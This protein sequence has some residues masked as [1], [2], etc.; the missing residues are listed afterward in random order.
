[1]FKNWLLIGIPLFLIYSLSSFAGPGCLDSVGNET[2]TTF[3]LT[4][5]F[6][7]YV[8]GFLV[9]TIE[10]PRVTDQ[11]RIV[12]C[13][14]LDPTLTSKKEEITRVLKREFMPTVLTE[15]E[16]KNLFD[17]I[18][19][20]ADSK[21][22][23]LKVIDWSV[24]G[25]GCNHRVRQL[26]RW[27]REKNIRHEDVYLRGVKEK[28]LRVKTE[29]EIGWPYHNAI[30]LRVQGKDEKIKKMVVDLTLHSAGLL[31]LEDWV[32]LMESELP[33]QPPIEFN[34]GGSIDGGSGANRIL[35]VRPS[36]FD[37]YWDQSV[38]LQMD[39]KQSIAQD[40][41]KFLKWTE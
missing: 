33:E 26:S 12:G 11:N 34:W 28:G 41:P 13:M 5:M 19:N 24:K 38:I 2:T 10:D 25:G 36:E 39:R 18:Q 23:L 4:Q 7:D 29:P 17:Q 20:P 22:I 14:Y 1:M 15:L 3:I 21:E 35:S 9:S 31:P 30:V 6:D 32:G 8:P 37:N 27:L 16:A 40:E